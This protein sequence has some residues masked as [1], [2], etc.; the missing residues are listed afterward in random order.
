MSGA[1]AVDLDSLDDVVTRLANLEKSIEQQLADLD[2][3]I[4]QIH[5]VWSGEAAAAQLAAHREWMAGAQQ[6]RAGLG[7]LRAA[8]STAHSNYSAAVAANKQMWS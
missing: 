2:T 5:G 3:R 6:M 4:R 1:F 7:A 8:A